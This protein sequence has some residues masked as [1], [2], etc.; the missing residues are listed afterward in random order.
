MKHSSN[1]PSK[2]DG[3]IIV[4]M[5]AVVVAS[6]SASFVSGKFLSREILGDRP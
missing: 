6:V 2:L 4:Q 1:S 5:V 3:I